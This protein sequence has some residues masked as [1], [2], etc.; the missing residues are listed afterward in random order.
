MISMSTQVDDSQN[1]K[2]DNP[3]I[4]DKKPLVSNYD[5]GFSFDF[6]TS[7]LVI[8]WALLS[9]SAAFRWLG[10]NR[11]YAEYYFYYDRIPPKFSIEDTRFEPAF[12]YCAWFFRHKLN[13]D[14]DI[15]VLTIVGISLAIKFYLIRRHLHHP[16]IAVLVYMCIFY[17]NHEYTQVR[18]AIS[19]AVGYLAIHLLMENRFKIGS[20]LLV[21]SYFFHSSMIIVA[22]VY[23]ATR[24]I[25]SFQMALLVSTAMVAIAVVP[26]PIRD[27]AIN[28]FSGANPL[29]RSY[30]QNQAAFDD[31]SIYSINNLIFLAAIGS[32]VA[33]GWFKLGRYHITFL[34]MS[35]ASLVMIVA[36]D[37]SPIIA[38]RGKEVLFLSAIFVMHRAP[39]TSR[40]ILPM[41]L[42]WA[43]AALLIYLY[44]RGG[45]IS[46]G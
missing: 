42:F 38:Q 34:I 28:A 14:Y 7:I 39:I 10:E 17:P 4:F 40:T 2:M 23:L 46:F 12:H 25:R 22:V 1:R 27:F 30:V 11:D 24:Y 32:A 26:G 16:L 18:A 15:F 45:L 9:L 36:F 6:T 33:L 31:A 44:V 8:L 41:A 21:L 37:G 35:I 43:D 5:K 13:F 3:G 20:I 29:L 19:L